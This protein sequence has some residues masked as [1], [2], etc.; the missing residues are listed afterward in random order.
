MPQ[1]APLVATL[2]LG[3][4]LKESGVV[5]QLSR[6]ASNELINLSTLFLGLTVGSLMQAETFLQASTLLI[7]LLGLGAFVLDTVAGVCFGKILALVTRAA[8]TRSSGRPASAP[9]R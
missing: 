8:S 6:S 4:L 3:S 7:L 5:Q 9:S 1:S 2:M